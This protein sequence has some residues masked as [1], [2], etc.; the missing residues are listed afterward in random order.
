MQLPPLT[1]DL[2]RAYDDFTCH[3]LALLA[4][5]LSTSEVNAARARRAEQAESERLAGHAFL[6]DGSAS[7]GHYVTG[8]YQ[9]IQRVLNLISKG[10]IFRMIAEREEPLALIQ[11][12]LQ[13][14]TRTRRMPAAAPGAVYPWAASSAR[15]A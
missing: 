15:R 4:N 12:V 9:P 11:Q 13:R 14:V 10:D 1:S 6:E 8:P 3:G 2:Q 5:V 7:D